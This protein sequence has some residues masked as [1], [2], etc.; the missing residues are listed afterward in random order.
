MQIITSFISVPL[1]LS[2]L[3]SERFALW[4]VVTTL[5]SVLYFADFGIGLGMQDRLTKAISQK[6]KNEIKRTTQ[7]CLAFVLLVATVM[8]SISYFIVPYFSWNSFF[9]L[10]SS[11]AKEEINPCITAFVI[12]TAIGIFA[13]A[14]Q[15]I[16]IA[17]Q[18]GYV[19]AILVGA[20]KILGLIGL[21]VVVAFKGDL[22]I[23]VFGMIGFGNVFLSIAGLYI[24]KKKRGWIFEN[25]RL[26]DSIPKTQPLVSMLRTGV[27]GLGASI[28]IFIVNSSAPFVLTKKYGA[29]SIIVYSLIAKLTTM[30]TLLMTQ[31]L[32]PLWPAITDAAVNNDLE[33]VKAKYRQ[34]AILIVLTTSGLTLTLSIFSNVILE[35]WTAKEEFKVTGYLLAPMLVMMAISQWNIVL[36]VFLNGFSL[37][38]SQATWG[39]FFAI[40]MLFVALW[41]PSSEEKYIELWIIGFGYMAR[42]VVMHYELRSKL[43]S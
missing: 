14:V 33:W 7:L 1:T 42:C 5:A 18:E 19:A 41:I 26:Q 31:L 3:G 17:F 34:V 12:S 10:K 32:A 24:L 28:A 22:W 25:Y 6:N 36:S 29:E 9:D 8:G 40:S 37:F 21:L 43:Y 2:Y 38:R 30:G 11:V 20:S 16:F 4:M 27:L 23:L 35:T 39:L 15:R 13:A